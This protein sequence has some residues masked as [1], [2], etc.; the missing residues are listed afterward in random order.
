MA[1]DPKNA[2]P[3]PTS[4]LESDPG[5]KKEALPSPTMQDDH[6]IL[7][8]ALK[9]SMQIGSTQSP[10]NDALAIYIFSKKGH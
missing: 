7:E 4:L 3:T 5:Q 6:I 8:R 2:I 9:A 1:W 10:W